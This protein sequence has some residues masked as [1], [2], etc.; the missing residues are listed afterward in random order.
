[1]KKISPEIKLR[2][3]RKDD[4]SFWREVFYDSVRRHFEALNLAENELENI[5]D[6]QFQAQ[7]IDYEKNYPQ[8][9]NFV[10]LYQNKSAGRMI[11]STEQGDLHLIDLSILSDFRNQGIGTKILEWLFEQSRRTK[12]PIRF[13]VEK[14]NPAFRLYERLGFKKA[15]DVTTHFQM[16]WRDDEKVNR[17]I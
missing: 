1:M 17:D 8:A 13:Y 15:A 4:E 14:M 3:R 11:H 7:S 10:I 16:E 12:L 2:P 5:L 6:F 9:S